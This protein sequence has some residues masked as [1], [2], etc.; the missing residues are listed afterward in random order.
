MKIKFLILFLLFAGLIGYAQQEKN[1]LV[2]GNEAYKKKN[3]LQAEKN[4]KEALEKKRNYTRANY[5]LGNT[6][7]RQGKFENAGGQY[8]V[9]LNSTNN[10]DTLSRVYHN[11][12][13]SYLKQKK[14]QEAVNAYKNSLKMN[15]KDEET[16][17]NLAFAL[18]KL[19]EQGGGKNQQQQQQ[20][21]KKEQQQQE[22]QGISKEQ[23]KQM[24]E[25]LKNKEAEIQRGK[26]EKN[27][28]S[29]KAEVDKDW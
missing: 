14:Y 9:M 7:Y 19:K 22:Q 24:L 25:E 20:Q 18:K 23:A 13:N 5:N 17:Y 10:K 15:P 29:R 2:E 28:N 16:R 4:Y 1:I 3:Y 26:K 6:Y 8:D 27:K 11:M 21:E 12:G